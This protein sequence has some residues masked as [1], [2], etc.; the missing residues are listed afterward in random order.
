MV[1]KISDERTFSIKNNYVF[2]KSRSDAKTKK[3]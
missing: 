1:I 2:M 3:V